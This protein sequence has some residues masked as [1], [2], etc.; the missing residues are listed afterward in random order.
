MSDHW[1]ANNSVRLCDHCEDEQGVAAG[2]DAGGRACAACGQH[3]APHVYPMLAELGWLR[4]AL[5][6]AADDLDKAANQF[7]GM[8]ESQRHGYDVP[9]EINPER[10]TEKAA[11]ARAAL[12]PGEKP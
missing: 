4:Q 3:D 12:N 10:F 11:R 8:R 6:V 2:A 9:V 7:D 1:D 5:A